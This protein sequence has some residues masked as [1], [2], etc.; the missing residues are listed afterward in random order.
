MYVALMKS[1]LIK[2][3]KL[4]GITL[5]GMLLALTSF[6]QFR[7]SG[8]TAFASALPDG[9]WGGRGFWNTRG[10]DFSFNA[11]LFTGSVASPVF[12]TS[13]DTDGSLNPRL[14]LLLG[15]NIIYFAVGPGPGPPPDINYLGLNLYFNDDLITNRITVAVPNDGSSSYYIIAAGI[16]IIGED[17]PHPSAGSDSYTIGGWAVV[18]AD[19]H[20]LL[21]RSDLVSDFANAPDGVPDIIG[22]FTLVVMPAPP[23]LSIEVSEVRL[24]WNSET[25]KLYQIQYRSDLTT[26]R[27]V[28]LQPPVV[29]NG[30]IS[31]VADVVSVPKRFYRVVVLP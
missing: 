9:A 11:Y 27:W 30:G 3:T 2:T 21:P 29:G 18:L 20:S 17:G 24:S 22:G 12:L 14:D 26:N 13:G 1:L 16:Q 25:N 6:A 4:I 10:P 7:L 8:V 28:N 15:T 31:S 19:F 5:C 23:R